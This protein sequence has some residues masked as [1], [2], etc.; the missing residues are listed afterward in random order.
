MAQILTKIRLKSKRYYKIAKSGLYV[1][2]CFVG[3]LLN[4]VTTKEF[5][6]RTVL[7]ELIEDGK[8]WDKARAGLMSK[9]YPYISSNKPRSMYEKNKLQ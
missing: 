8:E 6:K 3:Y 4:Q 2:A 5:S 9:Y 7:E 1:V